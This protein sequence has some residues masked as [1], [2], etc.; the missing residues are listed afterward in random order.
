MLTI[1]VGLTA[2]HR[3]EDWCFD[4]M[5]MM[6]KHQTL[7]FAD[8]YDPNEDQVYRVYSPTL[9]NYVGQEIENGTI[10]HRKVTVITEHGTHSYDEAGKLDNT[11][12]YGIFNY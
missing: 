5:G 6:P 11:W 1:I 2:I 8:I 4:T 3:E 10:D 7:N 9:I 12:P